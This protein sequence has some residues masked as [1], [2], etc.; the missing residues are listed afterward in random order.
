M[1][2]QQIQDNGGGLGGI[3]HKILLFVII[4]WVIVYF[5][6]WKGV[7]IA[8]PVAKVTVIGPYFLFAIL[9]L[10]AFTLEGASSG[11]KYLFMPKLS[12]LF[13]VQT[14]YYALD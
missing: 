7:S 6:I 13:K 2:D 10:K 11:L 4:S 3:N 14:W 5:A 12:E 1:T 9:I 8:G